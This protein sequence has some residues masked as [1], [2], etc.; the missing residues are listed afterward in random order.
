MTGNQAAAQVAEAFEAGRTAG[1]TTPL[2]DSNY[3]PYADYSR[4]KQT[5][6]REWSVGYQRGRRERRDEIKSA[7]HELKGE[8]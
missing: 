6:N 7:C 1:A 5:L 4:W 8:S 3:N 2:T